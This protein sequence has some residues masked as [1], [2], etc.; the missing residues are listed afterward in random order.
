MTSSIKMQQNLSMVATHLCH[1]N[2]SPSVSL[3]TTQSE[4]FSHERKKGKTSAQC[5]SC[6]VCRWPSPL[7]DELPGAVTE[8]PVCNPLIHSLQVGPHCLHPEREEQGDLRR[9]HAKFILRNPSS[10]DKMRVE[11]F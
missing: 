11:H 5:V 2:C 9:D 4:Q 1:L 8:M 3:E 6:A 7:D 10:L